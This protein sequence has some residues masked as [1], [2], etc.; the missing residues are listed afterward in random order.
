MHYVVPRLEYHVFT[1]NCQLLDL[2]HSAL[3]LLC[4]VAHLITSPTLQTHFHQVPKLSDDW[5]HPWVTTVS[6]TSSLLLIGLNFAYFQDCTANYSQSRPSLTAC[7]V[8]DKQGSP[9]T[10]QC[11]T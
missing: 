4:W 9:E 3:A 1:A 2:F 8:P 7:L 5:E 10:P 11:W 6:P